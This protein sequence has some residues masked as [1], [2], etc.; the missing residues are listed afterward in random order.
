M[1]RELTTT[2]INS[3]LL[4]LS[5]IVHYASAYALI[6]RNYFLSYTDWWNR[7]MRTMPKN[8]SI[9]L[10]IE[11]D[12]ICNDAYSSVYPGDYKGKPCAVKFLLCCIKTKEEKKYRASCFDN[13]V[14]ILTEIDHSCV[15]QYF[16]HYEEWDDDSLQYIV[17]E[18]CHGNLHDMLT[19]GKEFNKQNIMSNIASALEYIHS[20]DIVHGDVNPYN[21]L[22][23]VGGTGAKLVD[24]GSAQYL[25]Q[26]FE[27]SPG[28][29]AYMPPEIFTCK[30]DSYLSPKIDMLSFGLVLFIVYGS[31][32][33]PRISGCSDSFRIPDTKRL[34]KAAKPKMSAELFD[35]AIRCIDSA[36]DA[37]PDTKDSP[38]MSERINLEPSLG[39]KSCSVAYSSQVMS[40]STSVTLDSSNNEPLPELH[41]EQQTKENKPTEPSSTESE[42]L[43]EEK[44]TQ[45][46]ASKLPV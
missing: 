23:T 10:T 45:L 6:T 7:C 16:T 9:D 46:H 29:A 2:T 12:K 44:H 26:S 43:V 14:K 37:R 21:I 38:N 28:N 15:V 33:Q 19:A 42:E 39:S 34:I 27:Q 20:K 30:T 40:A 13:E 5:S 18:R 11:H 41:T 32:P 36:P 17:M 8:K 4:L 25:K 24:F 1:N 35:F 3:L 22:L 31:F